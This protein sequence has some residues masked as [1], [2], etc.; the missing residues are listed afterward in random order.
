MEH[1]KAYRK[2][3]I[4]YVSLPFSKN[5]NEKI[6]DKSNLNPS[7]SWE[8]DYTPAATVYPLPPPR[9]TYTPFVKYFLFNLKLVPFSIKK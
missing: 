4:V 1:G 3:G 8:A 2:H 7:I 5:A 6:S 9:L